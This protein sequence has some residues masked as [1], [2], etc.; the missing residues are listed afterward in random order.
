VSDQ[1]RKQ[2]AD[3]KKEVV[4]CWGFLVVLLLLVLISGL[5]GCF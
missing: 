5:S 1:E 2:Y 4:F 3:T